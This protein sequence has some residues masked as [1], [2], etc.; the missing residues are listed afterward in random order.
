MSGS[1]PTGRVS[2]YQSYFEKVLAKRLRYLNNIN[3]LLAI[4]IS[5]TLAIPYGSFWWN[6]LLTFTIRGPLIFIALTLI[7]LSRDYNSTVQLSP[8]KTLGQQIAYTVFSKK[9]LV[10]FFF[11]LASSIIFAGVFIFQLPFTYDYYTVSKIYQQKAPINDEWVYYWYYSTYIAVVYTF[12]HLIFQR[13][14]LKFQYGVNKVK[15]ESV[16]F[17]K[18]P[19]LFGNSVGLNVISSITGPLLYLVLRGFIYKANWLLIFLLGL[20]QKIPPIHISIKD[21]F[22]LSY[23]SF[24][25]LYCWEVVNHVYQIYATI[26]CLD[27]R[28]PISTYSSDP[29]NTLLSGLRN[30]EEDHQLSRLTA[31]QELAYI[32]TTDDP[33]GVKLRLAIYSAHSKTGY[34]WPSI[35]DECALVIKETTSRVNY[36][37]KF[38]LKKLQQTQS[39]LKD[40]VNTNLLKTD[41]DIFGNSY[42]TSPSS[43][44]N[45]Q[46]STS[47]LAKYNLES[48]SP[49][50]FNFF[51]SLSNLSLYKSLENLIILPAK[52][53]FINQIS[54]KQNSSN[55]KGN[56]VSKTF[57]DLCDTYNEYQQ[58][59][60]SSSFGTFF[61]VTLRRD[62][63]SRV[64]NP[65]NYG[66]A[67]ISIS[68]LLIHAVEE[69]KHNTINNNHSSDIINLLEKPI[70][71]C[72]NYTDSLPASIYIS[73]EDENKTR[74]L[75]AL[76][77][78]LT[79]NEFYKLCLKYN[80]KLNDLVLSARAFKLAKWVIDVAIA[81]QQQQEASQSNKGVDLRF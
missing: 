51:S 33:D 36:R 17:N 37:N 40:D 10:H 74:H 54:I 27:G 26:G 19:K 60:L 30:I 43:K 75:I 73:K 66:N 13:N 78:D 64:L 71:A 3:G 12:Q 49:N 81:Q 59:F 45:S 48:E 38:D 52:S 5:I 28:K 29:I 41:D 50:K 57:S 8:N 20:D 16:F 23:F 61:R 32:S 24:H 55:A 76:I 11:Y 42:F 39:I 72:S 69:D 35:L 77:H 21:L 9:S 47:P 6:L 68:N 2:S 14:R 15:P 7:K 1:K 58:S 80:Y 65:V 22:N 4:L 63:D 18:V 62:A 25:V 67:V 53:I 44:I 70:R 56:F 31:F 79:M 46:N 34:I